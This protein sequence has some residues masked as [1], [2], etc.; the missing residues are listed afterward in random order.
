MTKFIQATRTTPKLGLFHFHASLG[1][2]LG[3]VVVPV[4]SPVVVLSRPL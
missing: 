4:A 3:L 2:C 1:F